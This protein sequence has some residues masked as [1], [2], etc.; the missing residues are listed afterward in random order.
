M[1]TLK[2]PMDKSM[3]LLLKRAWQSI[4]NNLNLKPAM[5]TTCISR[6]LHHWVNQMKFHI[7]A[8]S[9]KQEILDSFATLSAAVAYIAYASAES[10]R[11]SRN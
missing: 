3:F 8:D 7:T 9:P 6:N 1:G 11:M 5:A 4:M 2:E 10:I